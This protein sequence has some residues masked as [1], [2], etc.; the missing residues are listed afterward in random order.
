MISLHA[1]IGANVLISNS[2]AFET[3][4]L[5]SCVTCRWIGY[6]D[7][8][9]SLIRCKIFMENLQGQRV[10]Q[11]PHQQHFLNFSYPCVLKQLL[12]IMQTSSKQPFLIL[13]CTQYIGFQRARPTDSDSYASCFQFKI[14]II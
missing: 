6:Y 7:L 10:D 11:Q 3:A 2:C 14:M 9:F 12:L 5:F 4:V 8:Q 1:T 13:F